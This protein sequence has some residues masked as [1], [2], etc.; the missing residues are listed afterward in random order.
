MGA[1]VMVRGRRSGTE[2]VPSPRVV[3]GT[4]CAGRGGGA[5]RRA[6]VVLIVLALPCASAQW[7]NDSTWRTFNNPMSSFLD[8]VISGSM[9]TSAMAARFGYAE[10]VAE[11]APS[12]AQHA[13]VEW[14][15]ATFSR[16][17]QRLVIDDL[18]ASYVDVP[19]MRHQVAELLEAGLQIYEAFADEQGRPHDVAFAFSFFVVVHYMVA[20]GQEPPEE[21]VDALLEAVT[22]AFGVDEVFAAAGDAERQALYEFLVATSM[23][24]T[25]GAQ[26]GAE[27]GDQE[28]SEAFRV[29]AA[30]SLEAVL[31][32]D[33]DRTA[34]T[35][36]G[37][38]IR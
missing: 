34:F 2:A 13:T 23:F 9:R 35:T 33:L 24:T 32:A 16:L 6:V 20:T 5:V 1:I 26:A 17:P 21:G 11:P 19:E 25:F 27:S 10:A 3:A 28:I 36:A 15:P 7:T 8:T 37:L 4:P 38:V 30:G 22:Y 31:G 29:L 18:A 14:R 12:A